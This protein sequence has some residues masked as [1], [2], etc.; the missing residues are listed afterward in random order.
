MAKI[1]KTAK[2]FHFRK[3][4]SYCVFGVPGFQRKPQENQKGFQGSERATTLGGL[5]KVIHISFLVSSLNS[6]HVI[7]LPSNGWV[8]RLARNRWLET[9]GPPIVGPQ[10][11]GP[12]TVGP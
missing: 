8:L 2:I 9:V 11:V 5:E 10:I 3:I 6:V 7:W 1:V 4:I 12:L